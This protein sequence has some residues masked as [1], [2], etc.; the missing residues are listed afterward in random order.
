MHPKLK[1]G[2]SD[3]RVF[4]GTIQFHIIGFLRETKLASFKSPKRFNEFKN[5]LQD[6]NL[7]SCMII[8]IKSA[9]FIYS[10]NIF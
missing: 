4:W 5:E 6:E 8:V 9:S 1:I 3:E 2:S 10:Q 7:D